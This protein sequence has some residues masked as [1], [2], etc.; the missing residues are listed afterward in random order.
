MNK[1]SILVELS[2]SEKTKFGKEDFVS[3]SSAETASFVAQAL[4]AIGAPLTADICRRAIASAFPDGLP[5]TPDA[6]SAALKG[7]Q[8]RGVSSRVPH[9][10]SRSGS[11]G[12]QG[13]EA[14]VACK[15]LNA[16]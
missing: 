9:R 1:N 6:I 8:Y 3:Q 5:P 10:F 12:S 15:R 11:P 4:E 7:G 14:V 13:S 16:P 2:E